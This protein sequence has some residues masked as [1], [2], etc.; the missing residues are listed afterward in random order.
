MGGRHGLCLSNE[1]YDHL[2]LPTIDEIVRT[3]GENVTFLVPLGMKEWFLT[4]G[5]AND[6]VYELDWWD[7]IVLPVPCEKTKPQT[8]PE[9]DQKSSLATFICVPAQHASG[10]VMPC[11][12][13]SFKLRITKEEIFWINARLFGADG[14]SNKIQIIPKQVYIMQ[15]IS[16][17]LSFIL[18]HVENGAPVIRDI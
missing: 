10:A 4:V 16:H 3:R 17:L 13:S 2:D 18:N 12:S 9:A 7:E 15:G 6:Q 14:S 8:S 5:L 11:Y 1:S